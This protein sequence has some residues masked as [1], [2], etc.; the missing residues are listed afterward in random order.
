MKILTKDFSLKM[1]IDIW[2][3]AIK[4]RSKIKIWGIPLRADDLIYFKEILKEDFN[5]YN[6]DFLKNA[7]V[8]LETDA[9]NFLQLPKEML[10]QLYS[11]LFLIK[12]TESFFLHICRKYS[13][14]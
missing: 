3:N 4:D 12:N 11:S 8:E 7:V 6:L 9:N 5:Y 14:K 1:T 10:Y 2:Y 13:G